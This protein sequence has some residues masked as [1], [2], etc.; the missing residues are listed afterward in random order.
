MATIDPA[1]ISIQGGGGAISDTNQS[2]AP[3]ANTAAFVFA[4][5]VT[6]RKLT[7]SGIGFS[8]N[9]T[10]TNGSITITTGA[11]TIDTQYVTA[12][13]IGFIPFT[14]KGD[15]NANLNVVLSAGGSGIAGSLHIDRIWAD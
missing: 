9:N 10:P 12:G 1:N 4:A 7:I 13:G 6:N 3:A 11:R 8:Y 14:Y 2:N 15:T 5:G